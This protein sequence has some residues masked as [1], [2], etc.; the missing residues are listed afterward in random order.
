MD[1]PAGVGS[2]NPFEKPGEA[3]LGF[4]LT[5]PMETHTWRHGGAFD[6]AALTG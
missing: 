6:E 5:F 2:G 1:F 4:P 3:L